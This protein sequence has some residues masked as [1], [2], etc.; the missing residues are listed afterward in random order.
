MAARH[1]AFSTL[2]LTLCVRISTHEI[3]N[4]TLNFDCSPQK[5]DRNYPCSLCVSRGVQHLCRWES[6][7]VARPAP[8]RPP[9]N[10]SRSASS[11]DLTIRELTARIAT[12][13]QALAHSNQNPIQLPTSPIEVHSPVHPQQHHTP[14]YQHYQQHQDDK[15]TV[16]TYPTPVSNF[17]S[18][19]PASMNGAAMSLHQS[20]AATGSPDSCH[21]MT[22]PSF[23]PE[24]LGQTNGPNDAM[25]NI[26]PLTQTMYD[27]TST[28]AQLSI[29]HHG[30][31]IGRGSLICA[32]HSVS[33]R[34]YASPPGVPGLLTTCRLA[35]ERPPGSFMQ[36]LPTLHRSLENPRHLFQRTP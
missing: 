24:P 22:P 3:A 35:Q 32:L 33:G 29:G 27:T 8:A 31:Y 18:P 4:L 16:M 28:L 21:G 17:A 1:L 19:P 9:E 23:S 7:P 6:V 34:F 26:K 13:E 25:V 5:C 15:S 10:I 36:N 30:E 20:P 14:P 11:H 2:S 12:L